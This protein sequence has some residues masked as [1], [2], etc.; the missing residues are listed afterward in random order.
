MLWVHW[1]K[2]HN[3]NDLIGGEQLWL[4]AEVVEVAPTLA[5]GLVEI[6]VQRHVVKI[7]L[8]LAVE[9]V[10]KNV[11]D[12]LLVAPVIVL[13]VLVIVQQQY[14]FKIRM[15]NHEKRI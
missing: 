11:K 6:I 2:E 12:V 14:R 1:V 7:V 5:R 13:V 15:F 10:L 4:L 8:D 9:L 3:L